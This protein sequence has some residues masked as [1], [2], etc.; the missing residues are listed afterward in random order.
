[1]K[2]INLTREPLTEGIQVGGGGWGGRK[3]VMMVFNQ[4]TL[5]HSWKVGYEV[6]GGGWKEAGCDTPHG[7]AIVP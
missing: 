1:M 6:G 4:R 7:Y 5:T 2:D 3:G